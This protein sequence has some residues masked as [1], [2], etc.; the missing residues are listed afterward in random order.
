MCEWCGNDQQRLVIHHPK[1]VNSRTYEYIWDKLLIDEINSYLS[2]NPEKTQWAENYFTKKTKKEL[3]TSVRYYEQK[4]KKNLTNACPFCG[5]TNFQARKTMSPKYRCNNC[6]KTFD[7]LK[8]RLRKGIM[9]KVN[10]LKTQLKDE[11]NLNMRISGYTRHKIFGE[12]SGKLLPLFYQKLKL[13]YEKKVSQLLEEYVEMKDVKVICIRC[14]NAVRIGLKWCKKCKK[15]YHKNA[16]EV[17]FEC[18]RSEKEAKDPVARKIREIFGIS[19]QEV[20][21]RNMEDECIMCGS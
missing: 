7:K 21:E 19:K 15:R 11:D 6:K 1:E 2:S 12:F 4:A 16:Y 14:H 18:H 10:A 20:W 9:N 3:K 5:G 8:Q 17:C 13:E